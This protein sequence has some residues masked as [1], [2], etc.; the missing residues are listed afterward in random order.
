MFEELK[1][2]FSFTNIVNTFSRYCIIP[3][4]FYHKKILVNSYNFILS[5]LR[6]NAVDSYINLLS[7]TGSVA[8]K[9]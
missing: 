5:N 8:K 6:K 2:N 3:M 9:N 7:Y 4:V 1:I